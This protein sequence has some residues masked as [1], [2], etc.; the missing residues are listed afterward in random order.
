MNQT[1]MAVILLLLCPPLGGCGDH[2]TPTAPS[3]AGVVPSPAPAPAPAPA[4][5]PVSPVRPSIAAVQPNV[6]STNGGAWGAITGRDFQPGATVRLGGQRVAQAATQS[7]G[8]MLFWT[9][10]HDSGA[11][12]VTVTNPGGLSDTLP[13][14]YV[15]AAPETFDPNAEWIAH[16]G[17]DFDTE[18]HFNIRQGRLVDVTCASTHLTL[19]APAAVENG[20]FGY[21]GDAGV[22]LSGRVVSPVNAVGTIDLTGC[23]T[24][25]WWAEK[26]STHTPIAR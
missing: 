21:R 7:D 20:E 26:S 3:A 25:S 12:D 18:V 16:A 15:Y 1:R 23:A 24:G 13:G 8:T 6:G 19:A 4:P 5:S 17:P 2:S 22:A 11:V 10:S 14:G 9:A